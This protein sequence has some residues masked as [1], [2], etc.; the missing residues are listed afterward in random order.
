M[1]PA[2]AEADARR[3]QPVGER[4][5]LG[6]AAAGDHD[7]V[8]LGALDEPLEDALLLGRLRERRVE[9]AVEVVGALDPEDAALAARVGRL[10]HRGHAHRVERPPA[11]DERADGCERRLRHAFLREG[12]AHHDLVAHPLGDG[13]ADRRQPEALRHGRD[14]RHGAVGRDGQRAVDAVAARDLGHRV[15]VGEVDGLADVGDLK[16]ERVGVAVDRDDADALLARLQDRAAL[17]APGADEEDGLHSGADA[18]I[19]RR[20]A[21]ARRREQ[22]ARRRCQRAISQPF[23]RL[24]PD[25]E[26]AAE[27][28]AGDAGRRSARRRSRCTPS[29]AASGGTR[30]GAEPLQPRHASAGMRTVPAAGSQRSVRTIRGGRGRRS[31]RKSMPQRDTPGSGGSGE[32]C[33][34]AQ[35]EQKAT[36]HRRRLHALG[37]DTP[38]DSPRGSERQEDPDHRR[39]RLHRDDA[40]AAARRRERGDRVRQPPP[41]RALGHRPRRPPEL[42]LRRRATCSTCRA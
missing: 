15:D 20:T 8:H 31:R 14:D 33:A 28:G 29:R 40:R 7:P 34:R 35:R 17:V 37:E 10:Q 21:A 38:L 3:P 30:L 42:P 4:H 36:A 13:C 2:D 32:R 22:E 9:V 27:V 1:D 26:R 16:P 5:D 18:T 19:E 24:E 23:A 11:F 12:A 25:P 6:R 41:R 39:R